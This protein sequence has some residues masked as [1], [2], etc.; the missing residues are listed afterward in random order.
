M[1]VDNEWSI[2]AIDRHHSEDVLNERYATWCVEGEARRL[3]FNNMLPLVLKASNSK[4]N[5]PLSYRLMQCS[6]SNLLYP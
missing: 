5:Y 1:N 6:L 2:I 3:P 4:I